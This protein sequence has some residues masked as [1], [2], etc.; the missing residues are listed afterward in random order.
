MQVSVLRLNRLPLTSRWG[1]GCLA[2]VFAFLTGL[3]VAIPGSAQSLGQAAEKERMRRRIQAAREPI[4]VVTELELQGYDTSD[5]PIATSEPP[6]DAPRQ[7][8]GKAGPPTDGG[9]PPQVEPPS[10]SGAALPGDQGYRERLAR[11]RARLSRAEQVAAAGGERR[12]V[13]PINNPTL[14]GSGMNA[15]EARQRV[16]QVRRQCDEIEDEARRKGIPPGYLR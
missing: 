12:I 13:C 9:R 11:C 10:L 14:R 6:S 4:R 7:G 15:E 1:S 3:A 2:G 8:D 5:A 16:V